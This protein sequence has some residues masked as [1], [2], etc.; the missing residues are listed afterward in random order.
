EHVDH[1]HPGGPEPARS[2]AESRQGRHRQRRLQRGDP[3]DSAALDAVRGVAGRERQLAPGHGG[4]ERDRGVLINASLDRF[5]QA[6]SETLPPP[7]PTDSADIAAA[8]K[9]GLRALAKAVT[10]ISCRHG[11]KRYAMT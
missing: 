2:I 10:V 9:I 5:M 3:R 11:T 6:S 7:Q 1:R 4:V 8:L